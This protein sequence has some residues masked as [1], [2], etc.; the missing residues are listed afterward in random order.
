MRRYKC[1]RLQRI[2]LATIPA[3]ILVQKAL[4]WKK[5]IFLGGVSWATMIEDAI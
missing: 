1:S 2:T 4:V 5:G 3:A